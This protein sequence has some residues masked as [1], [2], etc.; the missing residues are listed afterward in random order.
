MTLLNDA[1]GI[2]GWNKSSQF[3]KNTPNVIIEKGVDGKGDLYNFAN[4]K[5]C[6][7]KYGNSMDIITG[8]GGFDFS[9]DFNDQETSSTRLLFSQICF[10]LS[11]QKKGG[12]LF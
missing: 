12:F 5:S 10:A 11:L 2:P 8:D 4:L 7:E 3:L 1:T 6:A 9:V